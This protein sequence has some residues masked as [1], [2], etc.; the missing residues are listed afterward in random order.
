MPRSYGEAS[1]EKLFV[2][3]STPLIQTIGKSYFSMHKA[4][5]YPFLNKPTIS[6]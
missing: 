5:L 1:T 6:P 2:T 4:I 3:S